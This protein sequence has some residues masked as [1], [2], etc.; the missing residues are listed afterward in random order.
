MVSVGTTVAPFEDALYNLEVGEISKPVRTQFG[1]HVIQLL[2]KR[3]RQ[4]DRR[5]YHVYVRP[6]SNP[7]KIEEAYK[8]LELGGP[9]DAVVREFSEDTPS[10][11]NEGYI[12]WVNY[13]SRYNAALLTH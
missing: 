10:I 2:D 9:W 7:S 8:A 11:Q 6:N 13:G 12:G 4:A 5:V 1:Y 3:E